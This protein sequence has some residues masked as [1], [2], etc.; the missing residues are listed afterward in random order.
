MTDINQLR[1]DMAIATETA[2]TAVLGPSETVLANLD[3]ILDPELISQANDVRV[4]LGHFRQK[5]VS[6]MAQRQVPEVVMEDFSVA[7]EPVPEQPA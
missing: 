1:A 7:E 6:W 3:G 2:V 4:V 5:A